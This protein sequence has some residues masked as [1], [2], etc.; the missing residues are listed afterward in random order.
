M[1]SI[2]SLATTSLLNAVENKIPKVIDFVKELDY[3]GK[4]SGIETNIL[5]L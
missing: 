2:T 5:L 3:N 1:P 4:M